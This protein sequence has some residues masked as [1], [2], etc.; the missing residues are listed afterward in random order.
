MIDAFWIP[1]L[2]P[3]LIGLVLS[4]AVEAL[5]TPRPVAPWRRPM[6]AVGVHVGVWTLAFALELMLFRRPYF[7][8]AN[9]LAI[10]LLIVLVSNAKFKAL[11]E[12]FVYPDFE[13][14]MDA[15]KHP[16]LYLPFFGVGRAL[17]AGGGY[18]AALW[19][20]LALED[21]ITAGA[22]VWLVSF[23]DLPQEH[24]FDPTAPLVPFLLHSLCLAAAGLAI[25]LTTGRRVQV[26][27]EAVHDLKTS[28]L[29]GS[30]WAYGRA[31]RASSD[32]V[33]KR[34]PFAST[35][36]PPPQAGTLPDIVVIQSESFFDARQAYGHLRTDLLPNFDQLRGEAVQYGAL[37]VPAWG[38][39]TVRTEFGFL[40]GMAGAD[41]GIHRYNPYR[42][43]AAD[44]FPT[45]ASHLKA[46]GYRTICVHPYHRSF[47]N[48]DRVLPK[49]G[50]DEFIGLEAFADAVCDGPYVGDRV[51]GQRVLQLLGDRPGHPLYIHV[52]TMENHGP[53]HWEATNEDDA[54]NVLREELPNDCGDLIAY[55]RHLRN[56]DEMFGDLRAELLVRGHPAALCIFGDHVPIMPQVYRQ[57]GEPAGTTDYLM[58]TTQ[59][60]EV[61]RRQD[62]NVAELAGACLTAA[63]QL[64]RCES[65]VQGGPSVNTLMA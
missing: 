33:R 55:A 28:G 30:V 53:L 7:A 11:K 29:I 63:Q 12:P 45:L 50:F 19:A 26:S 62:C 1:L 10:E 36:S 24:T 21:S 54:R 4:F 14:F 23:A 64:S 59:R 61:P 15:I 16:R 5:L 35:A 25:A 39:N 57:L 37:D 13:Y 22:G 32:S 41:L 3:Y 46:Q 18:G 17:A 51:L 34:A 6:A 56:A 42:R 47:Y 52:I 60:A 2:P 20:G 49:M 38:A 65:A 8:V 9:V 48:R 40:S 43:L 27:F 44:G 31:E 58:W